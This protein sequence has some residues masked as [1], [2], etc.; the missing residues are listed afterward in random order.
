M[1]YASGN[2]K[3]SKRGALLKRLFPIF[4]VYSFIV[5]PSPGSVFVF[6][7]PFSTAHA[8][9]IFNKS[10]FPD[11]VGEALVYR[12]SFRLFKHIADAEFYFGEADGPGRYYAE[13]NVETKGVIGWISQRRQHIYRSEFELVNEGKR[14]R[15]L[16][17]KQ[18]IFTWERADISE[19]WMDYK[20]MKQ[21]WRATKKGEVIEEDSR[22]IPAGETFEDVLSAFYNFRS[23]VFGEI[24]KG[25]RYRITSIPTKG[26]THF[27]ARVAT[28]GE[29]K[30]LK[31]KGERDFE[32]DYM[33]TV[34]IPPEIFDSKTGD[35]KIWFNG[36]MIPVAGLIEDI[37]GLGAILGN[38][39]KV[40]IKIERPVGAGGG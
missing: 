38:L 33:I 13:L 32:S 9:Q 23:G 11:F 30:D 34:D 24:V 28:N 20:K 18:G 21:R 1:T 3:R 4:L 17:H 31:G 6:T 39:H 16:Y 10:P 22:D 14:L 26:I 15:S 29:R 25:K 5:F 2:N 36:N 19:S 7:S 27:D 37:K 35:G 8:E 40:T 12:L